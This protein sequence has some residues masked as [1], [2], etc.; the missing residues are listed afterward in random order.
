MTLLCVSPRC[1]PP[2]RHRDGC[3]DDR[4]GG[5]APARAADGLNLCPYCTRRIGADAVEAARLWYEIGWVL[6]AQGANGTVV[7]SNPH[8]GLNV[9][10]RAVEVRAEIRHVL[11]SWCR[12]VAEERG[13]HPPGRWVRHGEL[14]ALPSTLEG[15]LNLAGVSARYVADESQHA[16]AAFIARHAEW[17]AAQAFADD[18]AAE[19][20]DLRS[21]AW[22][23]AYPEGA[24]V[25]EI[26]TC[27]ET[28]EGGEPC[29]GSVR[30]LL[31]REDSLLPS[32]VVCD[33][34]ST[35]VWPTDRWR[36]LGRTLG[37]VWA[38]TIPPSAVAAEY[39]LP[40][41]EVYRLAYR[42]RWSTVREGRRVRY[43]TDDVIASLEG[44]AA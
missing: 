2:G 27:P 25:V 6:N 19:L 34:D 39:S 32:K 13:I 10:P 12:L 17:L 7:V 18:A 3:P 43:R 4:C 1:R 15:P 26:G 23:S 22:G 40:I 5:C 31:R 41:A 38:R 33:A 30:A 44:V 36:A 16:L 20:R 11:A 24:S 14:V 42:C 8:P 35:H 9:N 37:R 21:R 29:T 28:T